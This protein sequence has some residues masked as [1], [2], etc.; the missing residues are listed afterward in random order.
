MVRLVFILKVE[1]TKFAG[2]SDMRGNMREK[3]ELRMTP[4]FFAE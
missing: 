3:E 4:N 2:G 1:A